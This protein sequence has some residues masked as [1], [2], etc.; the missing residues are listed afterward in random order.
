MLIKGQRCCDALE[1]S[2][3]LKVDLKNPKVP[4]MPK[5]AKRARLGRHPHAARAHCCMLLR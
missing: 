1:Q 3:K 5:W 4:C 2:L